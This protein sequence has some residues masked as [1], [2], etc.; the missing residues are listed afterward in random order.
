MKEATIYFVHEGVESKI[1]LDSP[2]ENEIYKKVVDTVVDI[3]CLGGRV[4]NLVL[5]GF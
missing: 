1:I 2:F 4:N 5:E 3:V